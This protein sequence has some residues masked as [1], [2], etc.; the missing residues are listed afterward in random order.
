MCPYCHT[1]APL[2]YRGLTAT[3]SACGRARVPLTGAS[4]THAGKPA[5]LGGAV[6]GAFGWVALFFGLVFS[7]LLGLLVYAIFT[8]TAGLV[9]GGIFA[10]LSAGF[11]WGVR[12]GGQAL[13]QTGEELRQ[14]RA[15]EALTSLATAQGGVVT[16]AAAGRALDMALEEADALLTK[17][18][19][20][21]P[22]E[23]EVE[24]SDR[25]EVLYVFVRSRPVVA[26]SSMSTRP[27]RVRVA[28][29]RA[30]ESAPMPREERAALEAELEDEDEAEAKRTARR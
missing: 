10:L 16:A 12:R 15:V 18:A 4:L 17:L 1:N 27:A 8:A 2:V 20:T 19:K 21:K 23:V 29:T 24:V 3:C 11:F 26:S 5:R 22:D 9:V 7:T 14:R 30:S 25:G 13:E 28:S 6:L